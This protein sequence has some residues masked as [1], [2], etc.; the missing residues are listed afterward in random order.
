MPRIV[1]EQTSFTSGEVSF[2]VKGRSDTEKYK[3][4]LKT[5]ENFRILSQGPI[6]R[7]NGT[8]VVQP[9][10][11][12][13]GD[14]R[15]LKFVIS[16]T[17]SFLL[18]FGNLYIRFFT[19]EGAVPDPE[20]PSQPFELETVY[21]AAQVEDLQF[22]Q[23]EFSLILTH[24]D[25]VQ[26]ELIFNGSS[27]SDWIIQE[28]IASPP[29]TFES[30]YFPDATLT[31]AAETGLGIA[32][33]ASNPVFS[34]ADIGRS[35]EAVAPEI[36]VASIKSF[37]ST[38]VVQADIIVDFEVGFSLDAG[39]WLLDLSPLIDITFNS[40]T[41]VG[42][43]VTIATDPNTNNVF[44]SEFVG[45]YILANGG[46]MQILTVTAN[47]N[48]CEAEILK[49][50]SSDDTTGNWTLEEPTWSEERGF[51]STVTQAQQRLLFAASKSQ[52]Q[53]IWTSESGI[54]DGFGIG[55]EDSDSIE[56]DVVSNE[57]ATIQ[58]MAT[59]R[60]I[61]IGTTGGESTINVS[62]T[63]LTPDNVEITNRTSLKSD[64]QSVV[65]IGSEVLFIQK[66]D[67]KIINYFFDFNTDTFKGEDLT[68]ISE[69]ITKSGITEIVYGQEPNK[70]IFAVTN[71][72][73]LIS[74][75]YDRQQNVIG[76][77]RYITDG[78]F[79]SVQ[80]IPKDDKDQVWVIVQRN[81]QGVEQSFIEFF[82]DSSGEDSTDVFTDSSLVISNP[83]EI[84]Q[85]TNE[86]NAEFKIGDTSSLQ[87]GDIVKFKQFTQ[88]EG[89]DNI[90]FTID[91]IVSV[92]R[93]TC[94]YDS[95]SQ[96][97]YSGG[98]N[99]FK[100]FNTVT[101]LTHL[102]DEL[103]KI[104][105]DNAAHADAVVELGEINLDDNFAE[106]VVGLPVPYLLETLPK[107]FD[108]GAGPMQGQPKRNVRP[109]LR[110][111]RSAPPNVNGEVKPHI[112]NQFNMD[113]SIPLVSGDL[114]YSSSAW[115][116]DAEI[117][118]S[119][120]DVFPLRLLAIYGTIEGNVK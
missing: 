13:F 24:A 56:I 81:L 28:F 89:I 69:Q 32:F 100:T 63:T 88:W 91:N 116:F 106:V 82:D 80:T 85:V 115:G 72:G 30:G 114:Q 37:T 97:P 120:D 1:A 42:G 8:I 21:S 7:R 53:T 103:V 34:T 27:A 76:F 47:G 94:G 23:S 25:V 93:F 5:A 66:G 107:E 99:V 87:V 84:T 41:R 2:R 73:V 86:S 110:V 96:P 98:A 60:D 58:W 14:K 33:T 75:T 111:D 70:Q 49:S 38:T 36:G 29:P 12:A 77:T 43:I 83:L 31:A 108:F 26:Q 95:S 79:L 15:L 113:Q 118:I 44:Q 48:G 64:N 46:V 22:S 71:D 59:A 35:I 105:T 74:G 57:I 9:V 52:S 109:I 51:P 3:T 119:G 20:N 10:K 45:D 18:E 6:E 117:S 4:G 55:P 92:D 101:G 68:F 62:S 61:I 104:K 67:R 16:V 54:I 102:N 112:Q 78:K 11:V 39:E 50:M 17:Q 90:K 40:V 19:L 65:P